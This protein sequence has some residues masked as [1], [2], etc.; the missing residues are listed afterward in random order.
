VRVLLVGNECVVARL[1]G[2]AG[3]E[4]A[5]ASSPDQARGMLEAGLFDA[6]LLGAGGPETASLSVCGELRRTATRTPILLLVARDAAE[7]RV[8]GLDAGA[9]DCIAVSSPVDELLARLRALVRRATGPGAAT[10]VDERLATRSERRR[11]I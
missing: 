8:Q 6:I 7:T 10:W 3:H 9:D 4:V 11:T 1:L 5:V 2:Q